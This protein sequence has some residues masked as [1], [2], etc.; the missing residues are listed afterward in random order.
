MVL[1]LEGRGDYQPANA[2]AMNKVRDALKAVTPKVGVTFSHP[3]GERSAKH[4]HVIFPAP[5]PRSKAAPLGSSEGR[6]GTR[7]HRGAVERRR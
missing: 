1:P 4:S 5:S 6:R 3:D 7:R 2:T